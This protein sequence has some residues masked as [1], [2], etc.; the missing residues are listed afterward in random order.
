MSNRIQETYTFFLVG[1]YKEN[2]PLTLTIPAFATRFEQGESFEDDKYV[3]ICNAKGVNTI[4]QDRFNKELDRKDPVPIDFINGICVV[5]R[6]EKN[7]L[8]FLKNHPLR[9][10]NEDVKLDKKSPSLFK[11]YEPA[12]EAENTIQSQRYF[13][14]AMTLVLDGDFKGKLVPI[15]R[16]LGINVDKEEAIIR[17]NL[18]RQAEADP[19][20]FLE[21][22]EDPTIDRFSQVCEAFE[23]GIIE[24]D[25]NAVRFKG[26][27]NLITK[28]PHGMDAEQYVTEMSLTVAHVKNAW[29]EVAR[30]LGGRELT[31]AS[32]INPSA[33]LKELKNMEVADVI[34]LAIEGGVIPKKGGKGSIYVWKT[35]DNQGTKELSLRGYEGVSAH[36]ESNPDDYQSLLL[37]LT[38]PIE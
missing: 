14:K 25:G 21:L 2:S 38:T 12:K 33:T 34:K 13:A 18:I 17:H 36:F 20:Y 28:V 1:N 26:N 4:Y 35:K 6:R 32:I 37:S 15:A 3:K 19:E 9:V 22:Y 27:K 8:E 16:Y 24:K 5:N 11:L 30:R 7:K 29:H 31:E 23:K 10:G